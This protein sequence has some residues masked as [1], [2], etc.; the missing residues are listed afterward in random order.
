MN[1]SIGA[2]RWRMAL[3]CAIALAAVAASA[4]ALVNDAAPRGSNSAAVTGANLPRLQTPATEETLTANHP[5]PTTAVRTKTPPSLAQ[6]PMMRGFPYDWS[7]RHLIFSRP[8]SPAIAQRLERD[9]RYRIQQA[10]RARQARSGSTDEYMQALDTLA[11]QL[12]AGGT[13]R[14]VLVPGWGKPLPQHRLSGDW[15]INLGSGATV[16]AGRYPAKFS[17]NP[18]GAPNCTTDFVVFNTGLN[19]TSGGS[20]KA[21]L[22]AY[23]NLYATTC[24]S[25][26]PKTYW[27]YNTGGPIT[28]S[29]VLSTDGSQVAFVQGGTPASLVILR[30]V[31]GEEGSSVNSAP[32]PDVLCTSTG[33]TGSFTSYSNCKTNLAKSCQLTLP[34]SSSVLSNDSNSSPFYDY[35]NDII[36]V[37]DDDGFL[38]KFTGVFA[39]SPAEVDHLALA[40][41]YACQ[42]HAHESGSRQR[43]YASSHIR[44]C[45]DRWFI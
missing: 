5:L 32:S 20:G 43:R 30:P 37:G 12:A 41:D 40:G 36:Y 42:C 29:V 27:A 28:N 3:A 6:P 15:S 21:S 19:G 39:G 44:R 38:H 9:P 4:R 34:F 10:W 18:I 1:R 11:I 14:K 45:G 16:G 33:C 31:A 13:K 26:I 7:H 8:S 2:A 25:P 17:F 23:N 24:A 35:T 22:I